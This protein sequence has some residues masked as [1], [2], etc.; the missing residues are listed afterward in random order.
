MGS[1][2]TRQAMEWYFAAV[3]AEATPE[4]LAEFFAEDAE[5]DL[6]SMRPC[7]R[8]SVMRVARCQARRTSSPSP[9]RRD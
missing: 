6:F 5:W 1:D 9:P 8:I 4:L 2:D 7:Q 3:T